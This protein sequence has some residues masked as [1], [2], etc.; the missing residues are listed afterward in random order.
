MFRLAMQNP[1]SIIAF[2]TDGVFSKVKLAENGENLGDWEVKQSGYLFILKAGL[3]A[4]AKSE[5][6]K[7]HNDTGDAKQCKYL[8][9]HEATKS[10]GHFLRDVPFD[11]LQQLWR[12]KGHFATYEYRTTKFFGLKVSIAQDFNKWRKWLEVP[13]KINFFPGNQIPNNTDKIEPRKRL[14]SYI[15]KGCSLPYEPKGDWYEGEEG[16][17]YLDELD[18]LDSFYD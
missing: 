18:Q 2:A 15:V 9:D 17:Q 3:Y 12:E 11:R 7:C 14:T 16:E 8:C 5:D 4:F 13:R 10:R 6:L 1:K